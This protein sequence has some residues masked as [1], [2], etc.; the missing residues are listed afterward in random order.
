MRATR[1]QR[2]GELDVPMRDVFWCQRFG[3]LERGV[4]CSSP[5]ER[6]G[7][8]GANASESWNV[9]SRHGPTNGE[10]ACEVP[11]LRRAGTWCHP[12]LR[13]SA[14]SCGA[15]PTL[16]RAG[17]RCHPKR[18][19][20]PYSVAKCQRFGELEHG[21]TLS[22]RR[23]RGLAND[24]CQ[25]FGELER[26]VTARLSDYRISSV[27]CQRFGEL[28]RGVTSAQVGRR[29]PTSGANASESWNVVSQAGVA[30]TCPRGLR[31]NASESWNVVSPAESRSQ[32]TRCQGA[33]ASESWNVV[34]RDGGA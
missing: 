2:F 4:T 30:R 10:G 26:G 27:M 23:V 19:S 13:A 3:E 28:E 18:T 1:C 22:M 8:T 24:R 20:S 12:G 34:S 9:V 33:N 31:A 14:Q 32:C 16:R 17:T 7:S 6:S 11:T 21:V 29:P 25:R 5:K 15:V